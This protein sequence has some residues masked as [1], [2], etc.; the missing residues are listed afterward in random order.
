M[1]ASVLATDSQSTNNEGEIYFLVWIVKDRMFL[2]VF[3]LLMVYSFSFASLN[4]IAS[5]C[6]YKWLNEAK[7]A[8][9]FP[10][11]LLLHEPELELGVLVLVFYL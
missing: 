7:E 5:K 4:L 3:S 8:F 11:L 9:G 2:I 6:Y 1:R 10:Y